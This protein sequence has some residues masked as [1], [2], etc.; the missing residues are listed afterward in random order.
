MQPGNQP[1]PLLVAA[2]LLFFSTSAPGHDR[3]HRLS[4]GATLFAGIQHGDFRNNLDEEGE[5]LCDKWGTVGGMDIEVSF[6]ATEKDDLYFRGRFVAGNGLNDQWAGGLAPWATDLHD[7]HIDINDSGRN[8]LLEAWARHR[9]GTGDGTRSLALTAGIIDASAWLDDNGYADDE[10][11]H[12]MNDAF[13]T[14]A[15]MPSYDW[16][17]AAELDLGRLGL[18]AVYMNSRTGDAADRH[19]DYLGAQLHYHATTGIGEGTYRLWA[20]TTSNDFLDAGEQRFAS[21]SG[22]GLSIDQAA[23]ENFGV[24]FRFAWQTRQ[25]AVNYQ[26]AY[27]LGVHFAGT[28][29]GRSDDEAGFGLGYLPGGNGDIAGTRVAELYLRMHFL[30]CL[31]LTADLQYT[32]DHLRDGQPKRSAWIPGLRIVATF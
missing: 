28:L 11:V 1:R 16:G 31:D 18:N 32:Q 14:R 25:A 29:W 27:T 8:H 13:V 20:H 10:M 21:R 15:Y 30:D 5:P 3:D 19:F 23:G 2:I 7:D 17:A 9:F 12:F 6:T 26:A 24:F 4:L 22:L